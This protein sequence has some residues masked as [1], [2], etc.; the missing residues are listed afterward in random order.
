[1]DNGKKIAHKFFDLKK[2]EYVKYLKDY[3]KNISV[4]G[5]NSFMFKHEFLSGFNYLYGF[6]KTFPLLIDWIV[7]IQ[8]FE[9][10]NG[11]IFKFRSLKFD[12]R[13]GESLRRVRTYEVYNRWSYTNG[14][15]VEM[16]DLIN[17]G[18]GMSIEQAIDNKIKN[19]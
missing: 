3:L 16:D 18:H 5:T 7:N 14:K 10:P 8:K 2:E 6:E 11:T 15:L 13:R 19:I 4:K 1:M 12:H 17:E 9:I